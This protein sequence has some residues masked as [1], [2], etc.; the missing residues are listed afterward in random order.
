M[1]PLQW[2]L[3]EWNGRSRLRH[4]IKWRSECMY[5]RASGR[6]RILFSLAELSV[7]FLSIEASRWAGHG[8]QGEEGHGL[9]WTLALV[10]PWGDSC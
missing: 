2:V 4:G 9:A 7:L 10:S 1:H 6:S 5:F 3:G 8:V